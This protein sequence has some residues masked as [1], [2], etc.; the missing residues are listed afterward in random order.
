MTKRMLINATQEEELRVALVDNNWLYDLDIEIL[1][2]EQQQSSI[3]KG[4]IRRIE[5][6]LE[7][8]FVE[9]GDKRQGFLPFKE[10]ARTY[11]KNPDAK[12]PI[13]DQISV[14]QELIVQVDKEG[15]GNKGAALT[16]YISLAGC[17]LVLM[18]NNPKAGGISRRIEGGNR[19][20]LKETLE[21][22][23]VP[24]G[25]GVIARTAGVGRS[26]EELQWD[27]KVLQHQ[28]QAILEA[29]KSKPAPFLIYQESSLI[30]RS[31]RDHLRD[32]TEILVDSPAVYEEVYKHMQMMRPEYLDKVKLY[33]DT[34]PL[35]SKFNIESQIQLA[36]QR[37]VTLPSGG[38]IVIDHTEALIAIDINSARATKG[39]NIEETAH[40]TNLEAADEIARQ[41][42]LRDI[43]GLVVID[44]ID[45]TVSQNQREVEERLREAMTMDRARVQVGKISRFGLLEMSR[46]RLRPA[47]AEAT[48]HTCPRCSG[49]GTIRSVE[50]LALNMLRM[51]EEESIID[52]TGEVQIELPLEVATYLVNEKRHALMDLERKHHVSIVIIPN[53]I[54]TTPNFTLKRIAKNDNNAIE[55]TG[56]ASYTLA[57]KADSKLDQ[58]QAS[59]S[60]AKRNQKP[61]ITHNINTIAAPAPK[62]KDS[63]I[64]KTIVD[65]FVGEKKAAVTP[66]EN[67]TNGHNRTSHPYKKHHN[68]Q[69]RQAPKVAAIKPVATIKPPVE[70]IVIPVA[71]DES[72]EQRPKTTSRSRNRRRRA[73]QSN[74]GPR[75][76]NDM[77][78]NIVEHKEQTEV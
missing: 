20:E 41:L 3:F 65:F 54:L 30:V 29:A 75:V 40:K 7:A 57:T 38:A 4:I 35:F 37:E 68:N 5:P 25:M 45:M 11:F 17:Y 48:Q 55:K 8:I 56:T 60:A 42:R 66:A 61:V 67:V 62:V 74:R 36:F 28:W 71:I 14:D 21:Q 33:N 44:F 16:T 50:A 6:S 23:E 64:L 1:G 19:E 32:I 52:R 47:I 69:R 43:G 63:G 10:V 76:E 78:E 27:I 49:Q 9:Y 2:K 51:I 18:P 24:D 22:L 26:I 46:Q 31:I 13:K 12:T 15:R 53:P 58:R 73:N 34:A 39:T 59:E 77:Q 72:I 70:N